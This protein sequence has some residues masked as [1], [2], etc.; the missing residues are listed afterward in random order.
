MRPDAFF[1]KS[2]QKHCLANEADD[3]AVVVQVQTGRR[4]TENAIQRSG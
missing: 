2:Q 3:L 4:M 1:K